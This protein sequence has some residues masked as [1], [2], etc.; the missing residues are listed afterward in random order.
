MKKHLKSDEVLRICQQAIANAI[1][2]VLDF[3]LRISVYTNARWCRLQN[4]A[5]VPLLL[6]LSSP[7]AW[8]AS[9]VCSKRRR[10]C[11]DLLFLLS[12]ETWSST[13]ITG[14]TLLPAFF[15]WLPI[16]SQKAVL[17]IK[18]SKIKC[19]LTTMFKIKFSKINLFLRAILKIKTS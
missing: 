9:E 5:P 1:D 4:T 19:F 8:E 3:N 12:S 16:Y 11:S 13:T 17:K 14:A 15:F 6:L 2:R 7:S 10:R 18:C